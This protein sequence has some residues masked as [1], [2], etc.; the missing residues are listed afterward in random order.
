MQAIGLPNQPCSIR[1]YCNEWQKTAHLTWNR[2]WN[3]NLWFFK[4]QNHVV[5][6]FEKV[7]NKIWLEN[8]SII[9]L[10]ALIFFFNFSYN[11]NFFSNK[12]PARAKFIF[13]SI[14]STSKYS[15]SSTGGSNQ[16]GY[17]L[18]LRIKYIR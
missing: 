13:L 5:T 6:D 2:G 8:L 10:I 17:S 14:N 15:Y 11:Q 12:T 7:S 1:Y 16:T 9:P 18:Q 4:I 3:S